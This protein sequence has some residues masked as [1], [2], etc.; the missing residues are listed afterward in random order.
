[1][2]GG[3][4]VKHDALREPGRRERC[5]PMEPALERCFGAEAGH[6]GSR[7]RQLALQTAAVLARYQP[8]CVHCAIDYWVTEDGQPTLADLSG[9]FRTEWLAR[10]GEHAALRRMSQHPLRFAR[11]LAETGVGKLHVDFGRGGE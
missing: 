9:R 1:V 2:I 4:V 6:V 7:L 10:A 3:E 8:G 11:M 5:W